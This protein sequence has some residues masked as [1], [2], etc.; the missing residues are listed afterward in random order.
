[1]HTLDLFGVQGSHGTAA[2]AAFDAD[3]GCDPIRPA[4]RGAVASGRQGRSRGAIVARDRHRRRDARRQCGRSKASLNQQIADLYW[5]VFRRVSEAKINSDVTTLAEALRLL[6][7]E[8]QT[9]QLLCE[10]AGS[11]TSRCAAGSPFASI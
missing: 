7:F 1:M 5:F 4:G 11:E 8:R 6:E 3:R 2:T 10:K 9:W